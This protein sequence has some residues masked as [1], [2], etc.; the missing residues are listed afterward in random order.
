VIR[1]LVRNVDRNSGTAPFLKKTLRYVF[2]DHWSFML[3]ET[4]L[5][6]FVVL[7][8]TGVYLTFFFDPSS[9]HVPYNGGY[10]PLQGREV[11]RAY[12]SVV[13][14]SL[15]VKAGLLIRQTHHWAALVFVA[16]IVLHMVRV[17]FT[18]A[19]RRPR[20]LAYY[21]GLSML[22][23]AV[24]EGFAGYS[25]A[26]D[27][28]SGMGLAIA[29]SVVAAI[30]VVGGNVATWIWGGEFPGAPQFLPRLYTV[31]V[32]L[33]PVAIG[34]LLAGHLALVALTKHTQFP[35]KG[36]TEHNV[37]GSPLWPGYML[38]SLSLFAAVS[39]ALVLLGG[40]VQINPVWLWGPYEP[41]Q[42]TNAA[43]PDWYL[44]WLI[45]ALRLM[46]GFDVNVLGYT[47]VP[48]PFWGGLLFPL[49]VFGLLFAWPSIEKRV[50]NDRRE[51]HLLQRPRD[52]PWRTALG[53][54][55]FTWVGIV[56][57]YG[58]A[59][60]VFVELMFP[61]R[62]QLWVFRALVFVGPPVVGWVTYRVCRELS[63]T[64][65]RPLRGATVTVVRRPDGGY[66]TRSGA[67]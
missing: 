33:L 17:F 51:H 54:A 4:A 50:A 44:G 62:V 58:A 27:L 59:D 57:L 42:A 64:D 49:V 38:R 23:L 11:S 36:K 39:A 20:Q 14:L 5:Y 19:F 53:A 37:V 1:K 6:S 56:F 2:P 21:G 52:N 31:H 24:L 65:L 22:A 18:G 28:V 35:G 13:D 45:G 3:G 10:E 55:F 47:L 9:E 7:L 61:Y 29:Y 60:R 15:D 66:A 26:D 48:N 12:H 16:A 67:E 30:P 43:Q 41:Y 25:L 46:P 63:S 32:L 40:L 34:V 8:G